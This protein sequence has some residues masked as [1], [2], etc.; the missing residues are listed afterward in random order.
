MDKTENPYSRYP[1][2]N[3]YHAWQ[4]GYEAGL[5]ENALKLAEVHKDRDTWLKSYQERFRKYES[6]I[7]S[8]KSEV[9]RLKA[10]KQEMIGD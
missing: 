5:A 8:L 6:E 4:E 9:E 10:E 3:E 2:S 7:A 1:M